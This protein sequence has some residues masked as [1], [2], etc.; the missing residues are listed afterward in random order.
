MFTADVSGAEAAETPS[1]TSLPVGS[2][3]LVSV[4]ISCSPSAEADGLR[5][6][7]VDVKVK[8]NKDGMSARQPA[9]EQATSG[10][11]VWRSYDESGGIRDELYQLARNNPQLV[12][13]VVLGETHRGCRG[14]VAGHVSASR[15]GLL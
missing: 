11:Q 10:F 5:E 8:R 9:A 1:S 15:L 2:P 14:L 4:S 13:L 12:K 7:G 6:R 3:A